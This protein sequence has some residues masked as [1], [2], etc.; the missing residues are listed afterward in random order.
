MEA[1]IRNRGGI[2]IIWKEDAGFQAKGAERFRP[3]VISFKITAGRK[4]W[5]VVGANMPPNNQQSVNQVE[6]ALS[7]GP[8]GVETLM[9]GNLNP[10]LAQAR[11][12]RK[13]DLATAI[14]NYE[15]VDQK[16]HFI[17]T[18]RYRGMGGLSWG[19]WRDGRPIKGIGSYII[20]TDHR[21]FYNICIR[22]TRVWRT[23]GRSWRKSRG[24]EKV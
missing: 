16:L 19:M 22:E 7:C 3:N 6:Q 9:V 11:D 5:Y 15:L 21:Y 10:R 8:E 14:G 4:L 18:R 12:R 13:E 2:A 1:N 17:P 23:T 24:V 20:G